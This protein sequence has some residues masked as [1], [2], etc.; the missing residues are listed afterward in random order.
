MKVL[1]PT[2]GSPGWGSGIRRRNPRALG[3]EDQWGLSAGAPQDWGKQRFH[4]WR[5]HT[6]FHVHWDPAQ[7]SNSIGAWAGPTYE[8]WRVSWGGWDWLWITMGGG[9]GHW[10]Q[11][12]QRILIGLSSPR[13]CHFGTKTWCYPAAYR[14]QCGNALGQTTSRIETQPH[15]SADRLPKAVLSLRPPLNTPFDMVCPPEGEDPAPHTSG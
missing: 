6:R 10:W 14:L 12:T 3:F 13:G 2:S 9:Q 11:R 15:P 5:A 7:S 4:S 8:S 1:S